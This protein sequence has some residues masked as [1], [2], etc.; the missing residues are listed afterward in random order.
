MYPSRLSSPTTCT[1][2]LQGCGLHGKRRCTRADLQ[3][4]LDALLPL[5][6]PC[7]RVVI[8]PA[9]MLHSDRRP[10][11][12]ERLAK[13]DHPEQGL[14]ASSTNH[15][16]PTH[17]KLW[18]V[19]RRRGMR[20]PGA[21][22]NSRRKTWGSGSGGGGRGFFRAPEQVPIFCRKSVQLHSPHDLP[23]WLL[24]GR[25]VLPLHSGRRRRRG[26]RHSAANCRR[27]FQ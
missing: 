12:A 2:A 24:N 1:R 23:G 17:A 18:I 26:V 16:L 3:S 14:A 10:R 25:T 22:E 4:S 8:A 19:G 9:G 15:Q 6:R 13:I 7:R 20:D 21:N 27:I 11:R 5:L